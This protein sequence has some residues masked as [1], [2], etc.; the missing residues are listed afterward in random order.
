MKLYFNPRSRSVTIDWIFNELNAEYEQIQ[1]DFASKDSNLDGLH[2]INPMKKLP[3]LVD[4]EA[5]VTETAA[6][7][8]YLADKFPQKRLAPDVGSPERGVYYRYLFVAGNTIEP[9]LSLASANMEHL[10]AYSV[11]WGDMARVMDTIEKM[12]PASGWAL[13]D[14]FTA[15][16]IVFGGLL[17]FAAK[18]DWIAVSPKVAAY[19]SRIR[20]RPSYLRAHPEMMKKAVGNRLV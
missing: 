20:Q 19:I 15:A 18:F 16:D 8:A 2:R 11:G 13:G 12:T 5:V 7:C 1:I 10:D 4:G 6:I 17:D 14:Q 3:T 9:A